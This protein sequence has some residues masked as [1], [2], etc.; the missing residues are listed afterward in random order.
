[1]QNDELGPAGNLRR[2]GGVRFH[3]GPGKIRTERDEYFLSRVIPLWNQLPK[4][5]KEARS[6][7][8]FKAELDRWDTFIV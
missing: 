8:S 6:L 5:A 4:K 3:R 7:N 1:M 2:E